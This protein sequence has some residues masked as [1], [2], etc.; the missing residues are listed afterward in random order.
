MSR[1]N[2]E[3]V[4]EAFRRFQARD[5]VGLA[6]LWHPD[7]RSTPAEGWPEAGPFVGRDAVI[8]QFEGLIAELSDVRHENLE[9]VAEPGEWVV[10]S[11]RWLFRGAASGLEGQFD[12]A[13]AFRLRDGVADRGHFRWTVAEAL[14]AVEQEG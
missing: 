13:G 4:L 9:V 5:L 8:R 1:E 6:S 7:S 12:L 10:V 14:E 3:I 2:V 11:W